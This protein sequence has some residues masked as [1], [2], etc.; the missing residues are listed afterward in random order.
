MH[1]ELRRE[2]QAYEKRTPKSREAH[3][4]ANKRLP[5]G[6]GSKFRIHYPY[7]FFVRDG[8]S[9]P[10]H[11]LDGNESIDFN[12]CFG[13][14]M[15]GHYLP[16][17]V[18]AVEERLHSGTMYGMPHILEVELA[19][20]IVAHFPVDEVRFSNSGTEAT[21]H[22]IRLARGATGRDKIIKMEDGYHGVHNSVMVSVKPKADQY[23]DP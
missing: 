19:E 5:L 13:A 11:D 20:E 9:T 15:A 21:V 7:P 10:I 17:V 3:E 4:R 18:K 1:E 22:A 12:L 8:K 14:G 23:G 2:I 6:V 16:A